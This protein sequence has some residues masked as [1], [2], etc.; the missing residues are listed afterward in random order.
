MAGKSRWNDSA[1]WLFGRDSVHGGEGKVPREGVGDS[2][3]VSNSVD[4]ARHDGGRREELSVGWGV[5]FLFA[6]ELLS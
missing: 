6:F 2:A 4:D 5:F 1:S 3:A